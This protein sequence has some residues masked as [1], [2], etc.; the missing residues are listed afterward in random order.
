MV[1]AEKIC[2]Q[3]KL[4]QIVAISYDSD[5]PF[6]TDDVYGNYFQTY[7]IVNSDI[8]DS[9]NNVVGVIALGIPLFFEEI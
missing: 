6:I 5:K 1:H 4:S 2:R 8:V 9:S 3:E 7:D